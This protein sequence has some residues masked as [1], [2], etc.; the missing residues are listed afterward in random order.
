MT[1]P[2]NPQNAITTTCDTNH[3]QTK[4]EHRYPLFQI[5][6]LFFFLGLANASLDPPAK[7]EVNL[8]WNKKKDYFCHPGVE[9]GRLHKNMTASACRA[10]CAADSQCVSYAVTNENFPESWCVT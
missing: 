9:D 7:N 8:D 4:M 10:I 5:V 2:P 6:A 1:S 3:S